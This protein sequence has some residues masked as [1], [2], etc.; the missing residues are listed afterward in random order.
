MKSNQPGWIDNFLEHLSKERRLSSHTAEAYR[1]DLRAL[2]DYCEKNQLAQWSEVDSQHVRTF[3]ASC[4]RQGLAPRSIQRRL[5]AVRSFYKYLIRENLSSRNPAQDVSAP[6]APRR[7]PKTLDADQMTR[8]VEVAGDDPQVIRD[9]A[10]MELLYSSGLRLAEL[11]SLQIPDVDLA[12]RTVRVT[13]KGNKTRIVPVG[14]HALAAVAAWLKQRSSLARI[15]ETALF[16]GARGSR[17]SP[18][19]VQA[20]I[21]RWATVQGIDTRVS[22]HMFRHSFATHVL[23]SSG[24]LRAVQELLGHANISTTQIYTHLDFQHLARIYDKTH[25]RA[26]KR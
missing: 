22:P 3:A 2:L 4:H 23:E 25:P 20:R 13:G 6:K 12:D 9:R 26:R 16:V 8:L 17:I 11:V 14:R 7:L 24:D 18:R 19:T 1:R 21:R 15:D 5:S 10:M